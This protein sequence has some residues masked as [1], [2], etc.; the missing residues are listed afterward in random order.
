MITSK[1]FIHVVLVLILCASALA[2]CATAK[3]E[4]N[5]QIEAIDEIRTKLDLPDIPLE[6]VETAHMI[7]SP[8][9]DLEVALYQDSEG[10]KYYVEPES[11][12]VVEIDARE[13]LS[14][15]S[16]DWTALPQVEL[17]IKARK[18]MAATTPD[19]ETME[20]GLTYEEGNKGDN[21]FFTW[22]NDQEIGALNRP[23]AQIA[24][25]ASGVLFAYYNTL[26]LK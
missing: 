3:P 23:F 9:G 7:N 1:Y 14:S 16:T 20:T 26:S 13:I 22:R 19:F 25:H 10:H 2:G 15:I 8:D 21:Y 12:Q 5:P 17:S 11:N 18:M 24:F 4:G 6:F